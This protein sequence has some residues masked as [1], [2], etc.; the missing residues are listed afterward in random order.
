MRFPR[1]VRIFR[2]QLDAAPYAAVFV[3]LMMFVA[4]RSSLVYG[5][6]VVVELP[7][8]RDLAGVDGPTLVVVV[9]RSGQIYYRD[10]IVKDTELK[11]SL[12]SDA[13]ALK[14]PVT[15]V[16]Q[17]DKAVPYDIIVQLGKMAN[18][19]GIKRALLATRPPVLSAPVNATVKP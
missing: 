10:Q 18:E 12:R 16:I 2:G 13:L 1:N 8:A 7:S 4:L 11:V 15:L 14:L 5:P 3:L 19:V 9:D 17:A 6:G